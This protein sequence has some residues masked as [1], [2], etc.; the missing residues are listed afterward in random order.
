MNGEVRCMRWLAIWLCLVIEPKVDALDTQEFQIIE[1]NAL[2]PDLM[3]HPVMQ[4][5]SKRLRKVRFVNARATIR[6]AAE[7]V[8][9]QF[10][11]ELRP[12][13]GINNLM[14][15]YVKDKDDELRN[16]LAENIDIYNGKQVRASHILAG[17]LDA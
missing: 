8:H 11:E 13:I 10:R 6:A 14:A 5:I 15:H 2:M 3:K 7:I 17:I 1:Q 12:V 9:R 16:Y 4:D